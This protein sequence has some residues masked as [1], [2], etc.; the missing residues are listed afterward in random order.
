ML[1]LL[2]LFVC[3][4]LIHSNLFC[5]TE[6]DSLEIEN[7]ASFYHDRFHGQETSNGESY[8]KNDF[9]AAHRTLPFNTFLLV[10]NTLNDKSVVVRVN[11]RGPFKKSRVIDLTRSAAIKI[12]MVPF[13]VVPVKIEV[14][15]YLDRLDI[16]DS[17][18]VDKDVW[19]CYANKISLREKSIFIW[20]TEYWK[21]AFYMA[22]T[23]ALETKLDSIGVKVIGSGENKTYI[24][25]AT[26]LKTKKEADLLI[27]KFKKMGFI[28]SKILKK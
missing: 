18:F 14:L 3:F 28:H 21:H 7:N 15:T 11:D 4:N 16:N 12:D 10:T 24:V 1:R 6:T 22:S 20:R 25:V 17:L 13:G 8:N 2:F 26:G 27:H 23:L 19:D 9:T 5:Q